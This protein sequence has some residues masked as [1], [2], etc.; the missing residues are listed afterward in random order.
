[1]PAVPLAAARTVDS[2]GNTQCSSG[3]LHMQHTGPIR[4]IGHIVR[5]NRLLRCLHRLLLLQALPGRK[6]SPLMAASTAAAVVVAAAADG[7]YSR[8][9]HRRHNYRGDDGLLAGHSHHHSCAGVGFP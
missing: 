8:C 3:S 6:D 5:C 4:S 9:S 7:Y 1:M 2:I